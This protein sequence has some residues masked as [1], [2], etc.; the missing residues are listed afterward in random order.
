MP[1]IFQIF[2]HLFLKLFCAEV[3]LEVRYTQ[4]THLSRLKWWFSH[5]DSKLIVAGGSV[6]RAVQEGRREGR[7]IERGWEA[8]WLVSRA[9]HWVSIPMPTSMPTHA[10]G[11]W[12]GMGAMLLFMSGHGWASVLCIPASSSKS[13]SNFSDAGN[14]LT[15]KR[16]GLK[17]VT[18][19]DL[20]FVQSN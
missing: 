8:G 6:S 20:L 7:K 3:A 18:V 13:E 11:F 2:W 4:R 17:L 15:K 9:L 1:I 10:H 5:H 14:M 12:V 19:N 16:S